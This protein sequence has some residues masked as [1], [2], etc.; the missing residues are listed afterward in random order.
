V[1][2][3]AYLAVPS[4]ASVAAQFSSS[5]RG[6]VPF[7]D[8]LVFPLELP[9]MLQTTSRK[10]RKD[11]LGFLTRRAEVVEVKLAFRATEP[12]VLDDGNPDRCE[13]NSAGSASSSSGSEVMGWGWYISGIVIAISKLQSVPSNKAL[14]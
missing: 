6:V 3:K 7:P 9:T 11:S 4:S 10:R 14:N 2:A 5:S 13:L 12:G 1:E 8:N